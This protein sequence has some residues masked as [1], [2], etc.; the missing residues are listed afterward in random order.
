MN[1]GHTDINGGL[2]V[3]LAFL[4]GWFLAQLAKLLIYLL[5]NRG[6]INRSDMIHCMVKSGGMPS[7]HTASFAAASISIGLM[8]KF[9][10]PI[11]MLSACMTA[12]IIYDAVN[13]RHAVGVQ[14]ATINKILARDTELSGKIRKVK[15]VEG[16]TIPQIVMGFLIGIISA[17]LAFLLWTACNNFY[18]LINF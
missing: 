15:I 2:L 1:N 18:P 4:F 5:K 16:H 12:I 14:A 10:S 8:Y 13:V 6:N 11:F 3:G 7:G 9:T 17:E